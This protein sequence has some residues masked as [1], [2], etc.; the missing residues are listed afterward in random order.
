MDGAIVGTLIATTVTTILTVGGGA[1]GVSYKLGRLARTVE[2]A[3]KSCSKIEATQVVAGAKMEEL[4]NRV[5]S[6]ETAMQYGAQE[7]DR[8]TKAINGGR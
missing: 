5:T 2:D 8:L 6:L 1:L 4:G 7:L 3:S